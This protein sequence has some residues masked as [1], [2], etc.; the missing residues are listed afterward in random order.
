MWLGQNFVM[1]I[2]ETSQLTAEREFWR[3]GYQKKN[4]SLEQSRSATKTAKTE[5]YS[6]PEG[7]A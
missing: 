7:H 6:I 2:S 5:Q 1:A 3:Q 4:W